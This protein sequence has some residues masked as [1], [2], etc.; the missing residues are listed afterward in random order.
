MP[1]KFIVRT[2]LLEGGD[3]MKAGGEIF[4]EGRLAW[5]KELQV[6]GGP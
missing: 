4:L 6:H 1:D 5:V 2:L 3:R